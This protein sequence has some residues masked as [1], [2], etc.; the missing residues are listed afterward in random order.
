M[1]NDSLHDRGKA[2]EDLFF[3]D[4]DQQLLEKMKA[5]LTAEEDR[6]SLISATG[7]D[8][9]EV[10]NQLMEHGVSVQTLAGIGL[11][12]LVAV[13]WADG[14]MEDKEREA[15]LKA[16][17]ESGIGPDHASYTLISG[18]LNDRP[19][20][21]LLASWKDYVGALKSTLD[22]SAVD[23]IKRSVID[24]AKRVADSAGGFLGIGSTSNVEQQVLEE[25]EAAF[26]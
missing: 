10:I 12:P 15:V 19:A 1:T 23:Q 20:D 14:K 26:G 3:R 7:I 17:T 24:R 4:Q 25:L 6:S 5:E 11:I 22:Q 9:V 8:D 2:M 18:W 21:S 13:A 16:A